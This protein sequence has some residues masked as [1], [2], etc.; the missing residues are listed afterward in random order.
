M[1]SSLA[2]SEPDSRRILLLVGVGYL[3]IHIAD[4]Q[5]G[6]PKLPLRFMLKD[7]LHLG[8]TQTAFFIAVSSFPWYVKPLAG[9]LTDT[10]NL[11]GDRR[12]S[13]LFVSAAGAAAIWAAL[14]ILPHR[15]FILLGA[16]TGLSIC[17]VIFQTTL[18]GVLI[19]EGKRSKATGR[20]SS[21]RT[22]AIALASTIEGLLGGFLAA[23]FFSLASAFSATLLSL[24]A[25]TFHRFFPRDTHDGERPESKK[26]T[27]QPLRSLLSSGPTWIAILLWCLVV[28]SPG[29]QTPLLYHQTANL[30][31]SPQFIGWLRCVAGGCALIGALGYRAMCRRLRLRALLALGV[32]AHMSHVALYLG[33]RSR[34]SALCI[35]GIATLVEAVALLPILD[36]VARATPART[37]AFGY[38]LLFSLGNLSTRISDVLGSWLF[39]KFRLTFTDLIW[40]NLGTS[41]TAFLL[42]PFVPSELTSTRDSPAA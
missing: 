22:I 30:N 27:W 19:E 34:T 5:N 28:F 21:Q 4:F 32:F 14:I 26:G 25:V 7:E 12:R 17:L 10:V 41:L 35:E 16:C 33:Y 37:E 1:T 2:D 8:A 24:L 20:F 38:A 29:F 31:F 6:V 18:G 42:L 11:W 3:A 36:L 39:D 9:A 40:V 13:Y 15:Y 23:G